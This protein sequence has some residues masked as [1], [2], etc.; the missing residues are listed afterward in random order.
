MMRTTVE[1]SEDHHA[2][3]VELAARRREKGFSKLVSEALDRYLTDQFRH[4]AIA[5]ALR[6][7]GSLDEK[8]AVALE[9]SVRTLRSNW[10]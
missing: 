6:T 5:R 8:E 10:R 7:E 4:E 9:Q 2:R 1:I 3:L